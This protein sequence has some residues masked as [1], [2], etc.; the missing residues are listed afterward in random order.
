[1]PSVSFLPNPYTLLFLSGPNGTWQ[2]EGAYG[3]GTVRWIGS[4][5]RSLEALVRPSRPCVSR[6]MPRAWAAL[7]DWALSCSHL[8]HAYL[9]TTWREAVLFIAA[10]E[11]FA[12]F[13]PCAADSCLLHKTHSFQL[14][15]S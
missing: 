4:L 9:N 5:H 1:M 6:T 7:R 10:L 11:L 3:E 12:G 15:S 14:T 2:E 8:V 13:T